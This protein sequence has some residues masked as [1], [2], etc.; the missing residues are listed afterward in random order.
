MSSVRIKEERNYCILQKK[1]YF[2]MELF[3]RKVAKYT[4]L[5]K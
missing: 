2:R 3:L 5:G 1:T 4:D